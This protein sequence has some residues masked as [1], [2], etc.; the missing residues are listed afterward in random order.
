MDSKKI[1]KVTQ[2]SMTVK[3]IETTIKNFEEG[4]GIGPWI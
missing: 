3:D 4:Y 1:T 2:I